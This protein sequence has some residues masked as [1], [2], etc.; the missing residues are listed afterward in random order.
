M[1]TTRA[2]SLLTLK[3]LNED[4]RI[5]E[6]I[7]TTPEPDRMSDVVET[8]GIEYKL[9]MPFLWQHNSRQPIGKVVAV[10]VTKDGM[11][12]KAEIAPAGIAPFIDEAFALIKAGLVPGLSIGFRSLEE[13]YDRETGGYHFIR[14]ELFE[15]SAVTIPAHAS[16]NIT[17]VKSADA[18]LLATSGAKQAVVQL[19]STRNLPAVAGPTRKT[20]MTI[21][22]QIKSFQDKRTTHEARMTA[23]MAKAGETG[24]TLDEAEQEEY[25][26]LETEVES[27]NKHLSRLD[28]EEKRLVANA[29]RVTAQNTGTA[30]AASE[31]RGGGNGTGIVQVRSALPKGTTFS[32]WAIAQIESRGDRYRAVDIAKQYWPEHPEVELILR[33]AVAAG[34]TTGT[35]WAAPLIQPA[36]TMFNE[37]LELYRPQTVLGRIPGITMVPPNVNIPSQTAGAT[38]GWVGEAQPKPVSALALATISLRWAKTA[39]IVVLSKELIRYSSPAAETLVRNSL[40]KDLSQLED[41]LFLSTTA[42]NTNISPA[43]ILNGAPTSAATG[44]TPAAFLTDI[45]T[46][47]ATFIAANNRLSDLVI[48]MSET[49]ALNVG[50]L[51]DSLGNMIYPT[52]GIDGGT[53]LK[54]PVVVSEAV[55]NKI[56]FMNA[57]EIFLADEGGIEIDA[58]DQAS[59]LMDDAP[60]SS[61]QTTALVSLYQ[62]NL[63][64]IR[65]EHRITWKRGRSTSVYYLTNAAYTG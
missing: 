10:K 23:I 1:K 56:I 16:A 40:A 20:L 21:Q 55:G 53:L 36:Q 19:D 49:V 3:A 26:T 43:G 59:I 17:S 63:V 58:S 28:K 42:E 24:S 29:T 6:G 44:T 31:T 7:A 62:R 33:A 27:I 39:V 51:K 47:L 52:L 54:I 50:T 60:A 37:F 65:A 22:E 25:D 13:S 14:T 9:P 41:T 48:L 38:G 64:A 35:T 45:K 4:Q 12:I 46:A 2:Y 18:L 15:I 11:S 32:R 61:P 5:I 57:S 8:D 34:T 30:A